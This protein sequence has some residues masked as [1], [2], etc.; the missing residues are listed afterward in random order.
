MNP[1]R[2]GYV[3]VQGLSKAA[4]EACHVLLYNNFDYLFVAETWFVGHALYTRDR[5]FIATTTPA[6]RN[7]K[8]RPHG[9][10][11]LLGS[12]DA[13]SR[14]DRVEVTEHSITLHRGKLSCTGVYLPPSTLT[15]ANLTSLLN[16]ICQ[17]SIILGDI[18]TRFKDPVY[19]AGKSGPPERIRA[20][21]RLSDHW[22][23]KPS[24]PSIQLTTDHCFVQSQ[25][26]ATATL[27]LLRNTTLQIP[28][29][30]IYTLALTLGKA[31]LVD[32]SSPDL[33]QRFRIGRLR[34][35]QPQLETL[36]Q[37][38]DRPFGHQDTVDEMNLK[39]V[40]LCQ[41]LQRQTVGERRQASVS[42]G[43]ARVKP[44]SANPQTLATSIRLYKQASVMSGENDIILPTPEALAQQIDASTENLELF[45]QRWAGQPF[46]EDILDDQ[47]EPI[48]LWTREQLL[49]EIG[50]QESDKAC[51]ADGI[52][53]QFLKILQETQIINWLLTL[54]NA[55]LTHNTTPSAWNRSEIYLLTKDTEKR[56][57]A[58][59]LR[60]IS[61][62]SIFRKIFERLLLL[63][64]QD[65]PWAHLHPAQ[66]GFRRQYSTYTNSAVVHT[67][68][69]SGARS[70]AVFLDLKS[71]F[72][73]ID[74]QQLDAK[75]ATRGCP[76]TIRRLLRG[77][78]FRHLESRILINQQMT[79]WF[80]RA[81]GVLQGSPLSPWL[82]NLFID[83][84]L[85]E[86]NATTL[87]IPICLFYA[88][89]GVLLVDQ[90]M[91][92]PR[93]LLLLEQWTLRNAIFLNPAKCA[94]VTA[95]LDLPRMTIYGLP[96]ARAD[97]YTYLGFPVTATGIDFT[98]HLEHRMQAALGRARWLGTQSD[99]WGPAHR[100]R[101]YRQFLAPM[102]EYGA[103][104]VWAWARDYPD[105]FYQATS[106]FKDLMAWI[107]NTSDTRYKVT[108]NLCGLT[109]LAYRFQHL[110]TGYYML[111]DQ[112]D[113]QN[114]LRQL[115]D[116]STRLSFTQHLKTDQDYQRFK[117]TSSFEPTIEIALTR[118][119]RAELRSTIELEA[120]ASHLTLLIPMAS[121]KVPGLFLADITL[122]ASL[123]AQSLLLQYRR[124]VF[125]LNSICACKTTFRR[126]HETC[127]KLK[128]TW[129]LSRLEQAQKREMWQKL[130]ISSLRFTDL[131]YLLNSE[132][133]ERASQT[134]VEIGRQLRQIYKSCKTSI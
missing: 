61:I 26:A 134:L 58:T 29:D 59:N 3:N 28:T 94:V 98:R 97:M 45:R 78:M 108:A 40:A 96:I 42:T 51:G 25:Q 103:P 128:Q 66:A 111:L 30:H 12:Q 100:L 132:Q 20:F 34:T 9:G 57:D 104:L 46:Q 24:S 41:Q 52:H 110:A 38:W 89:D 23:L 19:Q 21:Q 74:H 10:I 133:V 67:L 126:G 36:V 79:P 116:Q 53:I 39:L 7:T 60:P 13:R 62:I 47:A 76:S 11:Y 80:I 131:D 85:V 22:H 123:S 48:A 17:S 130:A 113:P 105:L 119:L 114:P 16:S 91:D 69:V 49:D 86:V 43:P 87:G 27:E 65:Q 102:F 120:S 32:T 35:W 68:L 118:F 75:L 122:G 72:D 14:L 6:A 56:R 31:T 15:L 109:T 92:L 55:C 33:I 37:Q 64:V 107:S 125:M 99:G 4:W 44:C 93:I 8:G 121:R 54:Y 117:A 101:I 127:S 88:D 124:G 129:P 77:L 5:R 106:S 2:I 83:D 63:R 50:Y 81:R 115:L 95:Q 84:L 71:A 70:T 112:L 73:V 1:I 18:N 82:F 90:T